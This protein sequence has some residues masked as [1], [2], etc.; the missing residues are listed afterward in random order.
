MR[1]TEDEQAPLAGEL[2]GPRRRGL[3][4]QLWIGRVFDAPE[5]VEIS[6]PLVMADTG[7]LG[8]AGVE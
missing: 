3:E 1:L 6:R 5:L 2:G 8:E 4:L 7:S